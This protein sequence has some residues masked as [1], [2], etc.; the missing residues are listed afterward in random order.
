M[1]GRTCRACVY[2]SSASAWTSVQLSAILGMVAVAHYIRGEWAGAQ[3]FRSLLHRRA[4][5]RVYAAHNTFHVAYQ[6][7]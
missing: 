7:A 2:G 6:Y 4:N 3:Q 5:G 1:L